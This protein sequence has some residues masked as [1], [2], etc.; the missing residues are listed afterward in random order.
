MFINGAIAAEYIIYPA[1][2][3]F[4]CIHHDQNMAF[5][6]IAPIFLCLLFRNSKADQ[7]TYQSARPSA[8]G[9]SCKCCRNRTCRDDRTNARNGQC[10]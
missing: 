7:T 2:I 3:R 9:C 1:T 6:H 8:Y 5:I 10:T 4:I